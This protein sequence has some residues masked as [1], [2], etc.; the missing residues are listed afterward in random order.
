M[1]ARGG[2][3]RSRHPAL[4]NIAAAFIAVLMV[5]IWVPGL[6]HDDLAVP[7]AVRFANG[8]YYHFHGAAAWLLFAGFVL[9]AASIALAVV[10]RVKTEPGRK[11]DQRVA[12]VIALAGAFAITTVTLLKFIDVI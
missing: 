3:W 6:L 9:V 7:I 2:I 1:K 8:R 5:G 4:A 12:I 11:T 10:R